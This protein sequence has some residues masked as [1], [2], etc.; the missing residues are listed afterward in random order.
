ML[1]YCVAAALLLGAADQG[2]DC[3]N[4]LLELQHLHAQ[5]N[6]LSGGGAAHAHMA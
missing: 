4:W 5:K 2:K 1:T 6:D 3:T